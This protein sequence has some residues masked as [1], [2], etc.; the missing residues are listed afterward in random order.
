MT[1]MT[2]LGSPRR[3]GNTAQVLEWVEEHLKEMGHEVDRANIWEY[4]IGHC[5]ESHQCRFPESSACGMPDDAASLFERMLNSDAVLFASPVFCYGFPAPFKALIDRLY[6]LSGYHEGPDAAIRLHGKR[7]A[8]LMTCG[9]DE[10][11]SG[12]IMSRVFSNL[13]RFWGAKDAGFWLS[14]FSDPDG[15][16]DPALKTRA[17]GFAETLATS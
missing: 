16:V 17:V 5:R 3:Y 14:P 10:E 1:I 8:L 7:L 9:G 11:S 15:H 12:E 13:V 4:V 2:I 6:C